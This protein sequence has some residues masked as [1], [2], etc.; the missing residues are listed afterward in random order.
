MW[1][2]LWM[3]CSVFVAL[4][5]CWLVLW[6]IAG[7][8]S[9]IIFIILWA[10]KKKKLW[11]GATFLRSLSASVMA[12]ILVISLAVTNSYCY[13]KYIDN[14]TPEERTA[15][16]AKLEE[17]KKQDELEKARKEKE[18]ADKKA[19]KEKEKADKKAAEAKEKAEK[20]AAKEKVEAEK[21]A[22][23]EKTELEKKTTEEKSPSQKD[24]Q[25]NSVVDVDTTLN[26]TLTDAGYTIEHASKIT[27]ILNRLGINNIKIYAMTGKPEQ[28]LNAV[29]CYPNGLS[30]RDK[31]F[32]FTTENGVL[33]YAGFLNEDLY[34]IEKGGYL[35]KYSD[36][37]IPKKSV[38]MTTYI[39]LQGLAEKEIKKHLNY[40]NTASFGMLDWGVGRSDDNYKI[41]GKVTAKNAFGVEENA[42][43]SVW[44]KKTSSGFSVQSVALDGKTI[45]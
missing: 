31:R 42:Y 27:E 8:I 18:K 44:F 19:A 22:A 3:I 9:F 32:H 24:N 28:G 5:V 7:F 39:T 41:I 23:K 21:K 4:F 14:M 30:E 12:L 43:F 29:V 16:F 26:K 15:Y 10:K 36:V 20:K 35:K 34:D 45:K 11:A 40:P 13:N 1:E 37:H 25:A 33:F 2:A 17:E 6:L 38:D